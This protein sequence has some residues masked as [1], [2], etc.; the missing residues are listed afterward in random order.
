MSDRPDWIKCI[1]FGDVDRKGKTWRGRPGG[2]GEPF[3]IDP[4]HAALNG[5]QQGRLVACP[6]C[7]EAITRALKNGHD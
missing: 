1:G 6:E 4:T 3:F 7:V 5:E 2:F